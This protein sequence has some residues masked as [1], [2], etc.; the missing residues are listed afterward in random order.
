MQL[1]HC[2]SPATVDDPEACLV[3]LVVNI[4]EAAL[5]QHS[6]R[7]EAERGHCE[8]CFDTDLLLQPMLHPIYQTNSLHRILRRLT[9][10]PDDDRVGREPVVLV[11]NPRPV[12]DHILPLVRA[13]RFHLQRHVLFDQLTRT[14]LKTRLNSNMPLGSLQ[15]SLRNVPNQ[16]RISPG[17]SRRPMSRI[18]IPYPLLRHYSVE[19]VNYCVVVGHEALLV[20]QLVEEDVFTVD[21]DIRVA[22]LPVYRYLSLN[23]VFG[24]I[25]RYPKIRL[26]ELAVAAT[27]PHNLNKPVSRRSLNIR[28]VLQLRPARNMNELG[29]VIRL[30]VIVNHSTNIIAL[31]YHHMVDA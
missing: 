31:A 22:D 25:F 21:P 10:Q 2:V 20:L 11:E 7:D 16:I 15:N 18:S 26:A 8:V 4:V 9:R 6:Q 29:A 17:R 28:N 30:D 12:I 5:L 24:I 14:R 1:Q 23:L 13:E 19:Q 3:D 27:S